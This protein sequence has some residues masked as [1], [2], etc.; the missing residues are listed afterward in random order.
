MPIKEENRR[1]FMGKKQGTLRSYLY[2][3]KVARLILEDMVVANK[4]DSLDC[5]TYV[6]KTL[7]RINNSISNIAVSEKNWEKTMINA[8]SILIQLKL[9]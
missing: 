3:Q 6:G 9:K 8:Y 7:V 1:E 5:Y 2:N 4:F